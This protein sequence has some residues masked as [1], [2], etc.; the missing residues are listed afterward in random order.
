[1]SDDR[2]PRMMSVAAVVLLALL[3]QGCGGGSDPVS[4]EP[5]WVAPA[6]ITGQW[7]TA[8]LS[9]EIT[10]AGP[11]DVARKIYGLSQDEGRVSGEYSEVHR[12]GSVFRG[13]LT[14]TYDTDT[15]ELVLI[16]DSPAYGEADW[17]FRFESSTEM[18][19]VSPDDT[20]T[21]LILFLKP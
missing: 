8:V 12:D 14:G 10:G 16:H 19:Q 13:P 11:K 5:Q 7:I 15:G 1:M 4:P 9:P 17:H 2:I 21:G 6:E 3:A 18:W 20:D